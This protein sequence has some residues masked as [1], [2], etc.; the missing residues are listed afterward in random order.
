MSKNTKIDTS[1]VPVVPGY[2]ETVVRAK[3][4]RPTVLEQL[5]LTIEQVVACYKNSSSETE[6]ARKLGFTKRTLRKY[7]HAAD[8]FPDTTNCKRLLGVSYKPSAVYH[9]IREQGGIVPRSVRLICEQSGLSTPA[10]RAFLTRRRRAA[11]RHLNSLGLIRDL[12]GV[13]LVTVRG[14]R[15]TTQQV[16]QSTINVDLYDLSVEI[17]SVLRSGVSVKTR[18]SFTE[19]CRMFK[20]NSTDEAGRA[21]PPVVCITRPVDP[22][23]AS[24]S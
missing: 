17:K 4:G 19:Y 6:A 12:E 24:P 21:T 18:I 9:W 5:N 13:Q 15:Y 3:T 7:L 10:V 20:R 11:E 1:A 23:E 22:R 16:G 14:Q 8:V 2:D